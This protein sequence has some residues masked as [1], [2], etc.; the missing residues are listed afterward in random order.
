MGTPA[1]A[2]ASA[3]LSAL[4]EAADDQASVE[5][6]GYSV[7]TDLMGH[8]IGRRIHEQP[9]IPNW[10]APGFHRPLTHGLVMR[11]LVVPRSVIRTGSSQPLS[12]G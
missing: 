8:S 12:G 9:N 2:T 7:C 5:A 4:R 11:W 1:R 3:R 10:D 6:D